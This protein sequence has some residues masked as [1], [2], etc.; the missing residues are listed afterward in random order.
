MTFPVIPKT[1][2]PQQAKYL[3]DRLNNTKAPYSRSWR[4]VSDDE[5]R[6]VKAARK[7]IERHENEQRKKENE[8]T[9][10]YIDAEQRARKAILFKTPELALA[11]VEA[12]ETL[13]RDGQKD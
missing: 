3:R 6:E 13:C 7:L 9:Q 8:R 10:K 2:N 11:A 4:R 5:P 12:Y 1:C